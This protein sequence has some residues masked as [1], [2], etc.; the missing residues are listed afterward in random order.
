MTTRLQP[1][2]NRMPTNILQMISVATRITLY[3]VGQTGPTCFTFKDRLNNKYK[4]S[5]GE[6]I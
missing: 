6:R 3:L 4:V 2:R 5:I 1:Y